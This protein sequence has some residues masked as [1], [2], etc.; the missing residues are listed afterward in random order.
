MR[1]VTLVSVVGEFHKR[2]HLHYGTF[3]ECEEGHLG[4]LAGTGTEMESTVNFGL[5][6]PLVKAEGTLNFKTSFNYSS[7]SVMQ[8]TSTTTNTQQ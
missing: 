3:H 2:F 6:I 1:L 7:E 5:D 8:S 4:W